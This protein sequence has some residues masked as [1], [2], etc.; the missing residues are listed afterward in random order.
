[1]ARRA[2]V[3]RDEMHRI[4]AHEQVCLERHKTINRRL[5]NVEEAVKP[6]P[7][8]SNTLTVIVRLLWVIAVGVMTAV[9]TLVW[10][11]AVRHSAHRDLTLSALEVRNV[12]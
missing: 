9:G 11:V 12:D 2:A 3:S 10:E 7:V 6:I 1:M 4:D 5:G 8:M